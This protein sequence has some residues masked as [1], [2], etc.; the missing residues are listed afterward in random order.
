MADPKD[1]TASQLRNIF[2]STGMTI[3][4]FTTAIQKAEIEKHGQMVSF[5]KAE[6][7]LGHGNANLIAHKV[8]EELAGGQPSSEELLAAQY[9]GR[10][11]PLYAIYGELASFAESLGSDVEKVVQKTGVSF[12]RSKQFLLVQAPSSKRLQIGINLDAEP[13]DDR[14]TAWGGMCTHKISITTHDEVDDDVAGWIRSAY[15]LAR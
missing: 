4:T 2:D 5:L 13:A 14:V 9:A 12:R 3:N 11:Q 7:E 8:R 1:Q 6:Y 15:E 10:K